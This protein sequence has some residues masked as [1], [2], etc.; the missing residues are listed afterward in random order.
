MSHSSSLNLL[1]SLKGEDP[2]GG[3]SWA[4][5]NTMRTWATSCI[6]HGPLEWAVLFIQ[7][8]QPSNSSDLSHG[9]PQRRV[10]ETLHSWNQEHCCI[11]NQLCACF[12]LSTILS[13]GWLRG[14]GP[15]L[16]NVDPYVAFSSELTDFSGVD[17]Q[18][19]WT[20]HLEFKL[21]LRNFF[22]QPVTLFTY[23]ALCRD[24]NSL[25]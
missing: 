16:S 8:L 6:Y 5:H 20:P 7:P 12:V 24:D 11:W 23:L 10:I 15:S 14:Q 17:A 1:P 9:T 18:L 2:C 4:R 21:L 13:I 19:S 25:K 22:C 3:T